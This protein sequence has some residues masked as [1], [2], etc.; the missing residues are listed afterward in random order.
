MGHWALDLVARVAAPW[1]AVY[2]GSATLQ[3]GVAFLHFAGLLVAG[4]FAVATDRLTLRLAGRP[5]PERTLLLR[6]IRAVHRP[7]LIGLALVT[8]TGLAMATA[9]AEYVLGSKVFWLKMAAFGLLLGNGALMVRAERR[10]RRDPQAPRGWRSLRW[11]AVRSGALWVVTL[12][13][14]VLLTSM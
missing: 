2:G 9:D 6:E 8:V 12:L 3:T 14:G 4:G 7:V 1:S 10:A 13:L 5:V 11:S